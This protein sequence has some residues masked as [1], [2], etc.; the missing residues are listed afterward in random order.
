[1]ESR[2]TKGASLAE[3]MA[4]CVALLCGTFTMSYVS[5]QLPKVSVGL[6]PQQLLFK[7]IMDNTFVISVA[8][9]AFF[10]VYKF[11]LMVLTGLIGGLA[12][13]RWFRYLTEAKW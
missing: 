9:G 7:S 8:I 5:M 2:P 4:V 3:G 11:S 12:G 13:I 10:A 1:M 6:S